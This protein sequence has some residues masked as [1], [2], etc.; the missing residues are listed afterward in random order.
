MPHVESV[1][2]IVVVARFCRSE[3]NTLSDAI[4]NAENHATNMPHRR[5]HYRFAVPPRPN[6]TAQGW[7]N[8]PTFSCRW[9][10]SHMWVIRVKYVISLTFFFSELLVVLYGP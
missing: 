3:I 8:A 6:A 9:L 10:P 5:K 4:A 7:A 2:N 1:A